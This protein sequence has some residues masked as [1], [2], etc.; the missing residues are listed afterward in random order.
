MVDIKDPLPLVV[1]LHMTTPDAKKIV[2]LLL[3]MGADLSLP[4][5]DGDSI[6]TYARKNNLRVGTQSLDEII[7]NI[8]KGFYANPTPMLF[9][10]LSGLRFTWT[11]NGVEL[12]ST[13][14]PSNIMEEIERHRHIILRYWVDIVQVCI[15][16][17]RCKKKSYEPVREWG[18][19]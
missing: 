13:S 8:F 15:I 11:I 14:E 2:T 17:G 16:K 18:G 9:I 12:K 6:Y 5:Q 4:Y 7:E 19:G 3:E 10:K 1:A